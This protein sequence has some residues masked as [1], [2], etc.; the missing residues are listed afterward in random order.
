MLVSQI[1]AALSYTPLRVFLTLLLGALAGYTLQP[2]PKMLESLTRDSFLFKFV[3]LTLLALVTNLPLSENR[4]LTIVGCVV[5]ILLL[6]EYLRSL[7]TTNK[8]Q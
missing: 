7:P 1:N 6:L 8:K 4:L 5:G 3:V 2:L